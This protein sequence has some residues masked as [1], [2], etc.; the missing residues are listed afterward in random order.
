MQKYT[1]EA[2]CFAPLTEKDF[3]LLEDLC[4]RVMGKPLPYKITKSTE[5]FKMVRLVSFSKNKHLILTQVSAKISDY[6]TQFR[7]QGD[8]N[9]KDLFNVFFNDDPNAV[10]DEQKRVEFGLYYCKEDE[11][12]FQF[13]GSERPVVCQMPF[14][15]SIL[16]S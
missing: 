11:Y 14:S 13:K 15:F 16:C 10:Q 6:R 4:H 7:I 8:S 5:V 12:K 3:R 1:S 9:A 2:D